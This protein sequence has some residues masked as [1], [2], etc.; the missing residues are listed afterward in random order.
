MIGVTGEP[1]HHMHDH[2]VKHAASRRCPHLQ[3]GGA[4]VIVLGGARLAVHVR[5]SNDEALSGGLGTV[6][7]FLR[8]KAR[9]VV[10]RLLGAAHPQIERGG[11]WE[12][13]RLNP[14]AHMFVCPPT[15]CRASSS[16]G[17]RLET[18]PGRR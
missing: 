10:C 7:R 15:C 11:A 14:P 17:I 16:R 2:D 6:L 13:C 5:L 8:A 12:W 4:L 18:L 3:Q 1:V 9:L